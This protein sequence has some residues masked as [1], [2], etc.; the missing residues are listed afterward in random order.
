MSDSGYKLYPP[1]I[2]DTIPAFYEENGSA[3]I[4][5]PFSLN[6]A[7][8]I[9]DIGGFRIKIKNVQTNNL[10]NSSLQVSSENNDIAAIIGKGLV[11]FTWPSTDT[12]FKKISLG[13]YYKIQ[14]AFLNKSHDAIGYFS[15]VAIAKFTSKPNVYIL[16][17]ESKTANATELFKSQYVGVYEPTDDKSERPYSYC[18]NL[19]N[20]NRELVESSG[21]QLHNTSVN[22]LVQESLSLS[23]TIDTY[24][25]QTALIPNSNYFVQYT[26]RT[27]NNLEISSPIYTCIDVPIDDDS[28]SIA[29]SGENNFDNAYIGLKFIPTDPAI[30]SNTLLSYPIS[31]MIE[32]S[33]SL[34]NYENWET[35]QRAYF[36][37]Y[38]EIFQWFLRD[39]TVQQGYHYKYCYRLY[40]ANGIM[41][42]RRIANY[43]SPIM[44]DFEDMYLYADNVQLRIRYNPKMTS[45]KITQLEQK[46]ET[47]G[48]QYPY[49]FRNGIV[50]YREFPIS[51]M[52]SYAVDNEEL[53]LDQEKELEIYKVIEPE[54][55][56]TPAN[57]S[58][59]SFTYIR[60]LDSYAK[61]QQQLLLNPNSRKKYFKE[62]LGSTTTYREINLE[63][64]TAAEWN[65]SANYVIDS[66]TLEYNRDTGVSNEYRSAISL[67]SNNI[68]A[69]RIFKMKALEWLN[70]GKTKLFKSATEG[71]FLV[72]LMNINMQP[73]DKLGRMLHTV[74]MQASEVAEFNLK[75][76]ILES[77]DSLNDFSQESLHT[78]SIHV[79]NNIIK[80]SS[81]VPAS[82]RASKS[83]KINGQDRIVN[84][85]MIHPTDNSSVVGFYLRLGED[86]IASRILI[87]P[88][89]TLNLSQANMLLPDVYFNAYDNI[90]IINDLISQYDVSG[91]NTLFSSS[92]TYNT[93]VR[94]T[95]VTGAVK[96]IKLR[97]AVKM[98][99]GDLLIEYSC[100]TSELLIGSLGNIDNVH[101]SNV[102]ETLNGDITRKFTVGD[103]VPLDGTGTLEQVIKFLILNINKKTIVDLT[104]QNKKYYASDFSVFS[105]SKWNPLAIY[106]ICKPEN[107][108]KTN[109]TSINAN[110][111]YFTRST[112]NDLSHFT[113]VASPKANQLSSYYEVI[114]GSEE[115]RSGK[116]TGL[117]TVDTNVQLTLD[118]GQIIR[119]SEPPVILNVNNLYSK[120]VLGTGVYA[121]LGYQQRTVN[122]KRKS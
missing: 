9:S 100:Y 104:Y 34:H 46:I 25:F 101:I 56:G 28:L 109:D 87:T 85:L 58:K 61:A 65:N 22:Y 97:E 116:T 80:N 41:A 57:F 76:V 10:I 50:K 15:N 114:S 26:V 4:A 81:V 77:V 66:H 93:S 52:L 55:P 113:L 27:I 8:S 29:L 31:L 119:A 11:K 43:D 105:T 59:E 39:F 1:I 17:A 102:V 94:Y 95:D 91:S 54:R 82:L 115:Y 5:V 84:H 30:N 32:R 21:W 18:F 75:N 49:I 117:I 62:I 83:V 92:S 89:Q 88:H 51:G 13:Q 16:N 35:I 44:A 33:D 60:S 7:V 86:T 103:N 19:Y 78:R 36:A 111:H 3:I 14:I 40:D 47:I 69:E 72:R 68:R 118:T 64:I 45:F 23:S 24:E 106:R 122:Y 38:A 74:T 107:M 121:E 71:N 98:L 110:K 120:I 73:E 6:R 70:D 108:Q 37:S 2:G 112:Y 63:T 53:F 42:G 90:E 20:W 99:L 12:S 79:V 96:N 67:D 48:S